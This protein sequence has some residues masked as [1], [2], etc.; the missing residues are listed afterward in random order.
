[1]GYG[2]QQSYGLCTHFTCERAQW[3]TK[4][5]GYSRVWVNT[6]MG[7]LRGDCIKTFVI[8]SIFWTLTLRIITQ[9]NE[10]MM[11][12]IIHHKEC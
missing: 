7:Y 1:M 5:M 6:S 8:S 10:N 11:Q 9:E 2:L 3:T 4:P 12:H